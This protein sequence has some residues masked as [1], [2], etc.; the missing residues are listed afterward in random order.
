MTL[1]CTRMYVYMELVNL[2]LYVRFHTDFNLPVM[3]MQESAHESRP[4]NYE[5]AHQQSNAQ[6]RE[7]VASH[8][9]HQEAETDEHHHVNV[10]EHCN[11]ARKRYE[12][13]E[14]SRYI[15]YTWI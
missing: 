8:V 11:D 14:T 4:L 1:T 9:R 6:T 2:V 13:F 7:H 10:L 15:V 12:H 5:R 3:E